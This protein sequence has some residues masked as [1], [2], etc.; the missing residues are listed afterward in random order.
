M[1]EKRRCSRFEPTHDSEHWWYAELPN[2]LD[3]LYLCPG[4]IKAKNGQHKSPL[5]ANGDY[6]SLFNDAQWEES[7]W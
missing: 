7:E 3:G 1:Q 5:G 2:G 4:D 6:D